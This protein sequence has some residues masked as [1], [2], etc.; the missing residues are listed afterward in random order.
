MISHPALVHPAGR[1]DPGIDGGGMTAGSHGTFAALRIPNYRRLSA[2][3][4]GTPMPAFSSAL[5]DEQI[6]DIVN[7]VMSVPFEG[8]ETP[9]AQPQASPAQ[10]AATELPAASRPDKSAVAAAHE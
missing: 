6:W 1:A 3:I 7:Y 2:G 4:K 10:H 5:N 8:R 9:S